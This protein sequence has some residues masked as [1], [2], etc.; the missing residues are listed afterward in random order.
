MTSNHFSH[1]LNNVVKL[2][3]EPAL[4]KTSSLKLEGDDIKYEVRLVGASLFTNSVCRG[5]K[6]LKL[7]E[8]REEKSQTRIGDREIVISSRGFL[9]VRKKQAGENRVGEYYFL[10]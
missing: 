7:R 6:N 5:R 1:Y 9:K 3:C 10:L 8:E 4:K 2:Y